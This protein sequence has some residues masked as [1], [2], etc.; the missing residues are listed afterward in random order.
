MATKLFSL[1]T[2]N[3]DVYPSIPWYRI[4][5]LSQLKWRGKNVPLFLNKPPFIYFTLPQIL[6]MNI[7]DLNRLV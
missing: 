7:A 4:K 6:F 2:E 5:G 3:V 1:L